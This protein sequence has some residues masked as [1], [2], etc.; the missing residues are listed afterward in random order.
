MGSL[1]Q[2]AMDSFCTNGQYM[3]Y[4]FSSYPSLLQLQYRGQMEKCRVARK[5]HSRTQGWQPSSWD[6][7]GQSAIEVLP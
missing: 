3:F 1:S 7:Q 5:L 6:Q 2:G 4:H